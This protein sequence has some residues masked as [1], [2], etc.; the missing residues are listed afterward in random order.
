ML[1]VRLIAEYTF[2]KRN[3]YKGIHLLEKKK[4]ERKQEEKFKSSQ[5][6]VLLELWKKEYIWAVI[7]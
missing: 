6:C 5:Y 7:F 4:N 2:K 3:H 1:F